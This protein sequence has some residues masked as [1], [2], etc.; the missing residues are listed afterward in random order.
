MVRAAL[1]LGGRPHKPDWDSVRRPASVLADFF[2]YYFKYASK[3]ERGIAVAKIERMLEGGGGIDQLSEDCIWGCIEAMAEAYQEA[4]SR[5]DL[6]FDKPYSVGFIPYC[7]AKL[8]DGKPLC[9]R[10]RVSGVHLLE[11]VD[12]GGGSSREFPGL[13]ILT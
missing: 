4:L 9:K 2:G 13:R 5:P 7:A 3:R 6:V 1:S 11:S 8:R 12:S 10:V